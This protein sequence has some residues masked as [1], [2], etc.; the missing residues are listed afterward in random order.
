MRQQ[1]DF[2]AATLILTFKTTKLISTQLGTTQP[3]L[4]SVFEQVSPQTGPKTEKTTSKVRLDMK[5]YK[6]D[7]QNYDQSTSK[8]RAR[9]SENLNFQF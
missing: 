1:Q 9:R 3:Q 4:V 5:I 7:S 8:L 2:F 6:K